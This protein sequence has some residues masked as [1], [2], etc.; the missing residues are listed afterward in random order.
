MLFKNKKNHK[1]LLL[2]FPLSLSLF[3]TLIKN[4]KNKKKK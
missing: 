3:F 2:K 1:N 4:L